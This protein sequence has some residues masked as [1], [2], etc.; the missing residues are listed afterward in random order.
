MA[1]ERPSRSPGK[2]RPVP[3]P[4]RWYENVPA[5][6]SIPICFGAAL[7]GNAMGVLTRQWQIVVL[8]LGFVGVIFGVAVYVLHERWIARKD[9]KDI[10]TWLHSGAMLV[11]LALCLYSFFSYAE[12]SALPLFEGTDKPTVAALASHPAAPATRPGELSKEEMDASAL[13]I[14]GANTTAQ[15]DHVWISGFPANGIS[16]DQAAHLSISDADISANAGAGISLPNN[17]NTDIQRTKVQKNKGP[18]ILQRDAPKNV[19]R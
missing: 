6:V 14:L 9:G 15:I 8:S 5:Y 19:T 2:T 18:G 10:P 13:N 16:V 11:A 1:K 3:I 7:M 17:T 12:K 4:A